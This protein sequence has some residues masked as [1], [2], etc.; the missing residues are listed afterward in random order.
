MTRPRITVIT[1]NCNGAA[2][3]ERTMC[4]VLDQAGL[5]TNELAIEYMVV[6][7]GSLDSSP[8]II[9]R[10][11]DSLAWSGSARGAEPAEAVNLALARATG[12]IVTVLPVGDL[13]LPD[14]LV[15]VTAF[16]ERA[17]A[18]TWLIGHCL[19][20][21]PHDDELGMIEASCPDSLAALLMREDVTLPQ[22][23][24]FYH[25]ALL[26]R[27]GPFDQTLGG[28]FGHE[29]AC[30]LMAANESPVLLPSVL[31]AQREHHAGHKRDAR[32]RSAA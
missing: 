24:T 29:M 20:I 17:A 5:D 4:S 21:G 10:Y 23:A 9:K 30:R 6:D 25:R 31:A 7:T 11:A 13:Y 12:D 18:P 2:Y 19:R 15:R 14:A 26:E 1:P 22:S 8:Q 28:A 32:S 16:F 3:L 27:H